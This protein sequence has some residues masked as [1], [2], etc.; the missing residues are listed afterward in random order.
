MDEWKE[1]QTNNLQWYFDDEIS[2]SEPKT[3]NLQQLGRFRHCF[4]S[5]CCSIEG[6]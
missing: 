4:R 6:D 5:D 2:E 1:T 3:S